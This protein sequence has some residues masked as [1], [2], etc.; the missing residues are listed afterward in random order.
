MS[1]KE[2]DKQGYFSGAL[3]VILS[4][5]YYLKYF[6]DMSQLLIL[7]LDSFRIFNK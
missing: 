6:Q 2:I 3:M 7:V 1:E 4:F 5:V